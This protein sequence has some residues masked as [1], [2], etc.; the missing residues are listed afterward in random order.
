MAELRLHAERSAQHYIAL[1]LVLCSS[2]AV[3]N[4][5]GHPRDGVMLLVNLASQSLSQPRGLKVW[6]SCTVDLRY[7][8]L[9]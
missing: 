9:P 6:L 7:E 4:M 3:V 8:I 2:L 1:L 5:I